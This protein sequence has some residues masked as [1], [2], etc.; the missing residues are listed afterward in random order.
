LHITSHGAHAL[1]G[2]AHGAG[3]AFAQP[4]GFAQPHALGAHGAGAGLA[5]PHG[6]AHPQALGA[7]GFAAQGFAAHGAGAQG[8]AATWQEHGSSPHVLQGFIP[9]RIFPYSAH[10]ELHVVQGLFLTASR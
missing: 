2:A 5:Q 8:A 6:F 1:T 4:Q 3:A 7:H 9:R 10:G